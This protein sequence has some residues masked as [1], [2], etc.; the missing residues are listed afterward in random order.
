MEKPLLAAALQK[1]ALGQ[2]V[3]P[4]AALGMRTTEK[5][6]RDSLRPSLFSCS[7]LQSFFKNTTWKT[8]WNAQQE[9]LYF[10]VS[11]SAFF[12]PKRA[13]KMQAPESSDWTRNPSWE[14][15]RLS[16]NACEWFYTTLSLIDR[17]C[18]PIPKGKKNKSG[19]LPASN[20]LGTPPNRYDV[21][22]MFLL[23]YIHPTG[24]HEEGKFCLLTFPFSL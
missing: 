10:P 5:E 19:L 23:E 21:H 13:H 14:S 6:D 22:R 7:S 15:F 24:K 18:L 11:P 8:S 12:H 1:E 4:S 16:N 20:E 3:S 9:R 2:S 17:A